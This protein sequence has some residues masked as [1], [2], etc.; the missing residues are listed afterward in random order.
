M[1]VCTLTA[2]L[3]RRPCRAHDHAQDDGQ[4][5]RFQERLAK[6]T[7]FTDLQ[8]RRRRGDDQA[9]RKTGQDAHRSV[10]R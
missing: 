6:Y 4:H 9:E 1:T 2:A 7:L 10:F 8:D 3:P 5:E